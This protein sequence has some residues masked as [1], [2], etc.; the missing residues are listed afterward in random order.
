MS[1]NLLFLVENMVV[2]DV[3]KGG[4]L[5]LQFF[6]LNFFAKKHFPIIIRVFPL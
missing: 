1:F 4:D 2:M 5:F 3:I 6:S